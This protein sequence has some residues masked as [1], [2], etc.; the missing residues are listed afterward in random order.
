MLDSRFIPRWVY[1]TL[2]QI[3]GGDYAQISLVILKDQNGEVASSVF[4]KRGNKGRRLMFDLFLRLDA[5]LLQPEPNPLDLLD[6]H[7]LLPDVP[8]LEVRTEERASLEVLSAGDLDKIRDQ[9]PHVIVKIGFRNL[10][11]PI[12]NVPRYG[13][14][15]YYVGDTDVAHNELAGCREVLE[16]RPVTELTLRKLSNDQGESMVLYRSYSQTNPVYVGG[17]RQKAFFKA[18]SFLPR[19]LKR[20]HGHGEEEFFRLAARE[21]RDPEFH[22][23]PVDSIP[24]NLDMLAQALR[25]YSHYLLERLS[26][27]IRPDRW[28]LFYSFDRCGQLSTSLAHF[29]SLVPPQDRFWAD[30][31]IVFHNEKYYL[32]FEELF[33]KTGKGHISYFILESDG[34]HSEPVRVL[35]KPYHLSY[36]FIFSHGESYYMIP[37]S[38]QNRTIDLYECT[39]FPGRWRFVKTLMHDITAVDTTMWYA[40]GTWWLFANVKENEGA[41]SLDELHLFSS[42]DLF[43]DVWTPHPQNPV[44]TDARS[45]RPAGAIFSHHDK[46]YR[47]S[48]DCSGRYG[49]GININEIVVLSETEYRERCISRIDPVWQKDLLGTHTLNYTAG[50]TVVDAVTR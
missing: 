2:E 40:R 26:L 1:Q 48:Q 21:N 37:E 18:V 29:R 16:R 17:N 25:L 47:P 10:G 15:S 46:F 41:S 3:R 33:F 8:R 30:P 42:P 6:I 31:F 50:L 49:K 38:C 23:R 27:F 5:R 4:E 11:G 7:Q 36:P 43:S 9:G 12:L 45:A 44:V 14:W 35:E 20:L 24:T 13:V 19:V 34:S 28:L 22:C 32:F 39:E